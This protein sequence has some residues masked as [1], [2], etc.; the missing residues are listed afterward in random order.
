MAMQHGG[1]AGVQLVALDLLLLAGVLGLQEV[2][3]HPAV[4]AANDIDRYSPAHK[5]TETRGHL[6]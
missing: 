3:H 4:T 2:V 6:K 5:G 1:K